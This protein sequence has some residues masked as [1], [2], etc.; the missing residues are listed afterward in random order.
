MNFREFL[1][2][3]PTFI[4]ATGLIYTIVL[5]ALTIVFYSTLDNIEAQLCHYQFYRIHRSFLINCNRIHIIRY[6]EVVMSNGQVLPISKSRKK[7]F[8]NFQLNVERGTL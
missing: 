7:E 3:K 5:F 1:K 8:R 4:Y 6:A 2:K